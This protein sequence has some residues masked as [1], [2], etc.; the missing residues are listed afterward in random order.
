[1]DLRLRRLDYGD[2]GRELWHYYGLRLIWLVS[3]G[4]ERQHT[5][6][7][8]GRFQTVQYESGSAC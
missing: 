2:T 3:A 6:S 5:A 1:M 4:D 8:A 7:A